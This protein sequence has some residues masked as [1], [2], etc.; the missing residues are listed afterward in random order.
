M[1]DLI[2]RLRK[3]CCC[4]QSGFKMPDGHEL[5]TG[6]PCL[7]CESADALE[8]AQEEIEKH[9]AQYANIA[10]YVEQRDKRIEQL[11]DFIEQVKTDLQSPDY[12]SDEQCVAALEKLFQ[13]G[14]Y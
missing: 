8:Q 5:G 9:Q 12:N 3:L 13:K 7:N 10:G 1:N 14:S 6:H 4:T 2:E 11:E